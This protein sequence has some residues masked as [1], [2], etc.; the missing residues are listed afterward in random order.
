MDALSDHTILE[1]M[2]AKG[3]GDNGGYIV[4]DTYWDNDF[5]DLCQE[6]TADGNVS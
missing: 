1:L 5:M 4:L 2:G 6:D 3:T